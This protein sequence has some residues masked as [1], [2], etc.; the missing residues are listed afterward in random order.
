MKKLLSLLL[1]LCI[2]FSSTACGQEEAVIPDIEPQESIMRNICELATLECYY[3]NVAKY[4]K[5]DAEGI[6]WWKKDQRLWIEYA[7]IVKVGIDASKVTMDVDNDTVTISLPE[8]KVLGC[9]ID[10]ATLNESSYIVEKGSANID[11]RDQSKI[12][13]EAQKKMESAAKKNNILL[14]NAQQR[15][16]DL[17]E[18]YVENLGNGIG[19]KYKIKWIHSK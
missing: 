4:D 9:S 15:A 16:Q 12:L 2:V 13:D 17:L 11:A 14:S 1:C 6:L 7:G 18:D 3:H 10:D 8:A 5:K 19:K